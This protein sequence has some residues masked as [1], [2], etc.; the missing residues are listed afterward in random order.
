MA[1]SEKSIGN[2]KDQP[3]QKTGSPKLPQVNEPGSQIVKVVATSAIS[4]LTNDSYFNGLKGI[5]A[6]RAFGSLSN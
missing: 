3:V 5:D 1:I 6:L 2:I 4:H